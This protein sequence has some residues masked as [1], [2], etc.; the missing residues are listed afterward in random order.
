M[1]LYDLV[2]GRDAPLYHATDLVAIVDILGSNVVQG[3]ANLP[4]NK[5]SAFRDKD[6]DR[7]VDQDQ[8]VH[9]VSLTRD[10]R[11]A[12]YWDDYIIVFD[13]SKLQARFRIQPFYYFQQGNKY[14][15]GEHAEAE[16]FLMGDIQGVTKYISKIIVADEALDEVEEY[17]DYLFK[18]PDRKKLNGLM[19]LYYFMGDHESEM[20]VKSYLAGVKPKVRQEA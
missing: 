17:K 14:R 10:I 11:F 5:F 3:K 20:E 1:H 12:K 2:E 6:K 16:E 18:H 15:H 7:F 8:H 13:Q 4:V 19:R 9:G